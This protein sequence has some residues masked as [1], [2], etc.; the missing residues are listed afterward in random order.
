MSSPP[1]AKILL[2]IDGILVKIESFFFRAL[3][4]EVAHAHVQE[5]GDMKMGEACVRTI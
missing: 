5:E 2:A 1:L 3:A 4:T